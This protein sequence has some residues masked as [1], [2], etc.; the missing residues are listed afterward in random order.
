MGLAESDKICVDIQKM[1][2]GKKGKA[3]R[4]NSFEPDRKVRKISCRT[5]WYMSMIFPIK[6][7][8]L[9]DLLTFGIQMKKTIRSDRPSYIFMEV[10]VCLAIKW[11]ET[12]WQKEHHQSAA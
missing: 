6:V 5:V 1:V 2:F 7:N 3:D 8:T 11:T 4:I 12:L 9:M 10:D